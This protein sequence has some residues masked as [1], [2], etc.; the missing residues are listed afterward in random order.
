MSVYA[1]WDRG[2]KYMTPEL[3][4]IIV[5][6]YNVAPYLDRCVKSIVAQTYKNLEIILVDD[7]STD[8]SGAMCDS[9]AKKDSR[10]QVIHKS[11]GGQSEARNVGIDRS[12]GDYLSFADPDDW[13]DTTMLET[14]YTAIRNNHGVNMSVCDFAMVFGDEIKRRPCSGETY[15]LTSDE[16][17]HDVL[18]GCRPVSSA[19]VCNK[20]YAR[21]LWDAVRFPVGTYFE[22]AYVRCRMYVQSENISVVDQALYF[23]YQR[24]DSTMHQIKLST[25]I[26]GVNVLRQECD[27]LCSRYPHLRPVASVNVLKFIETVYRLKMEINESLPPEMDK[28][29]RTIFK[30]Y[31]KGTW[32]YLNCEKRLTYALFSIS[33]SFMCTV[34]RIWHL[35]N[36]V[37]GNSDEQY[38][39]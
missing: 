23:Y 27:F 21:H 18:Y 35:F 8:A 30:Q 1:V 34:L 28:K 9:W 16:A 10:I 22:D 25:R 24:E 6:V 31:K 15:T 13:L 5:P 36:R 3:I 17:I 38:E 2:E 37:I 14:L 33:P 11:N 29:L 20:L 39:G 19:S 4:S 26:D 32:K 7:G 12:T